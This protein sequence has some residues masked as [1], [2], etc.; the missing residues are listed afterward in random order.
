VNVDLPKPRDMSPEDWLLMAER[1]RDLLAER[2]G[3]PAGALAACR[4]LER[5]YPCYRAMWTNGSSLG[6]GPGH[7]TWHDSAASWTRRTHVAADPATLAALV[8]DDHAARDHRY[9]H[10]PEPRRAR[11][12]VPA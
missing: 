11:P 10:Y 6:P 5:Q 3:W 12:A 9:C 8:A 7:R 4:D 2:L 1:N